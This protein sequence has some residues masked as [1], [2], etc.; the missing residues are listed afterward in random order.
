[1]PLVMVTTSLS[2]HVED[3]GPR[4]VVDIACGSARC[5]SDP[6]AVDEH[7]YGDILLLRCSGPD[8]FAIGY[9]QGKDAEHLRILRQTLEFGCGR[10]IATSGKHAPPVSRVLTGE[11]EAKPAIGARYQDCSH[12]TFS[13]LGNALL[14]DWFAELVSYRR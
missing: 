5:P 14:L 4:I 1:M 6:R 2:I 7:I 11:F 13:S 3:I 12:R 10:R 9:V 8:A